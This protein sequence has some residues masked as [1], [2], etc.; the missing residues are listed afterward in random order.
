MKKFFILVATCGLALSAHSACYSVYKANQ[1][2][3]QSSEAPV[4]T[5]YQHHATVPQRFGKGATLIY[6]DDGENCPSVGKPILAWEPVSSGD[7]MIG[8]RRSRPPKADRG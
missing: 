5:R 4:D 2:I 8:E 6:V 1:L 3:Y 7:G